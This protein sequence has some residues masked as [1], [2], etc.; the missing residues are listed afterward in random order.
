MS[1]DPA[2]LPPGLYVVAT[3]IGTA[4]DITLRALDILRDADM[5]LAEDT[6][7]ARK[8]MEIHGIPLRGRPLLAYHDHNGA[9]Q[10]PRVLAALADGQ[11]VAQ[12]SDAGTPLVA[13]PGF[14]L[15]RAA[16]DA[17]HPV[18]SAP[19]PSA[20]LA[21]LAV[22][23]LPSDRFLFAGF[24]PT[25]DNARAKALR[26]LADVPATL[27]FFETGRRLLPSLRALVSELGGGR[28][29]AICRE[30]TK[31]FEETTRGTL[32]TLVA[33]FEMRDARGEIVVL[34]DRGHRAPDERTIKEKL[35]AALMD[36]TVKDA[37][38]HVS[39]ELGLPRRDIYQLALKRKDEG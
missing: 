5:L 11:R 9:K 15:V 22:A 26:E 3:P 31:K 30:L 21:A 14:A 7:R 2:E 6:R 27:V 34:V 38:K 1:Q 4:R 36:M 39:E 19:G 32:E 35:D 8:L 10:R 17:G 25:T 20:V 16:I 37:A 24:L 12:V 29:A 13:D 18:H 28:E 23:G 33:E